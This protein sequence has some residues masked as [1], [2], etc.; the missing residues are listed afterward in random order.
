MYD[1][2]IIGAGITGGFIAREL[3]RYGLNVIILEKDNDIANGTT[4]ANSAIVHAGYDA[5]PHSMK[6]KLNVEGNK[7]FDYI[8]EELDVPFKRIGSHVIAFSNEE[9]VIINELYEKGIIN[10]VPGL[11][12]IDKVELLQKE[13]NINENVLGA[14]YAP[15]AGIVGPWE[16]AIALMENAMENGVE[17]MLNSEVINIDK[18]ESGYKVYTKDNEIKTR[19]IVN[20]AGVHADEIHNMVA[21][22]KFTITPR[23]G[24][25]FLLDKKAGNIVNTVV[26]QCPTKI[27]KG[28]VVLPTVHGNLLVGP[29][30]ED[31][32]DK[33]NTETSD[34]RLNYVKS[35]S[36]RT[37]NKIPFNKVIT[38]FAG[39]RASSDT[40]DF[41]IKEAED[42]KGFID[43][44]GIESPGLSASPAI[45]KYVV[46]LIK[47]I[48]GNLKE[49]SKFNST[50]KRIIHFMELSEEEK[51]EIIKRD[52]RYGRI[53]C[54]CENITEGEIVDAIHRNAGARTVDGVKR[55]VRPGSGRCQGGFCQPRVIEILAR[56]LNKDIT[57][58]VKDGLNSNIAIGK[59]K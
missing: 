25:Y 42:A 38:S 24:Q 33:R 57:E 52:P 26:F 13:P 34:E 30:A 48:H 36:M 39:S 51:H 12:I 19:Y 54:R 45:G 27:S 7:M 17:L 50:R 1:V 31:I 29:D 3:S 47:E 10:K 44:A 43:V 2:V 46:E 28:V 56:E 11:R 58:I 23:R 4:K 35:A 37:S 14:L 15:T 41:I 8:C 22:P 32:E 53:I 59:T 16:L 20:C 55:R 40:G 49:N 18:L 9:M 5:K 6:A 21:A